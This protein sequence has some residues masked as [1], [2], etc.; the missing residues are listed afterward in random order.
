MLVENMLVEGMLLGDVLLK[1]IL[2]RDT[3]SMV[4]ELLLVD[5]L[6]PAEI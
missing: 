2:L 1:I 5:K 3:L 6:L 4:D